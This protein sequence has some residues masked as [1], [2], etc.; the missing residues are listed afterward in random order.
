V[1]SR[2]WMVGLLA[3]VLVA[4]FGVYLG[5][6][7]FSAPTLRL[8]EPTRDCTVDAGDEGDPVRLD[9]DQMANAATI[10]AIGARR[11]VSERGV[12]VALAT[13]M[14]ESKLEN[15]THGDRDSLGLF[16]QRPSQGWGK[17]EQIQDPRYAAR[18]FYESL[19]KVRGW[20][21]MRVTDAAQRV[22]RS[23]YP[24]AYEKWA[25]DAAVLAAA[26]LGRAT[27]AVA[28]TVQG[29]PAI[30]GAAAAVALT[31]G[32]VGDWGRLETTA[33][34]DLPGLAVPAVDAQSG[35]RYAHW[36]VAHATGHGVKR[37]A[38]GGMQW[39]ADEGSWSK[40]EGGGVAGQVVAEVFGDV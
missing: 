19:A 2:G 10:V 23:A 11:D 25:D 31:K 22:Q 30:T 3:L 7:D 18:K 5:S 28:C 13:A 33:A 15:L 24:E 26:F 14:Q 40:V 17:P 37:V 4:A 1:R 39:S 20:E 21:D 38:F 6:R 16:Q 12:V 9:A 29:K 35:W 32:L 8:P 36:L 34:G 27:G